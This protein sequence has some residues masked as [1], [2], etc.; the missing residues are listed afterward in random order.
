MAYQGVK[1]GSVQDGY[2]DNFTEGF[3][4]QIATR[5]DPILVDGFPAEENLAIGI[6]VVKGTDLALTAGQYNNLS[7][8]YTIKNPVAASVEADFVG[9]TVRTSSAKNDA[10]GV[11]LWEAKDMTPV[12]REGRIFVTANQTISQGD[13]VYL[14]IQDTTAHG[15]EIGSF[16]NADLGAD[17]IQLTKAN[18]WKAAN[19]GEVAIIEL[20][21]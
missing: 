21:K 17:T 5:D 16:S 10:N 20:T 19:A 14:I 13:P 8:P 18:F 11:P 3:P 15:F 7:A 4:G 6:G 1:G 2:F 9:V 12:M